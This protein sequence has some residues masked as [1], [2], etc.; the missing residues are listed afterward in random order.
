[1]LGWKVSNI[2]TPIH[3]IFLELIMGPT[4]SIFYEREPVES[5]IMKRPPRHVNQNMFSWNELWISMIQGMAIAF[6]ILSLYYT[7]MRSGYTPDYIR[8]IVFNTLIISN[9]FLTLVNR[10]FT[11]TID[12]TIRYKNA[13][14]KYV[15]LISLVFLC[16]LQFIKPV[17]ALFGLNA[18]Q[19]SHYML[20][21]GV[22]LI[23][24]GSF[25]LYK[26]AISQK[27]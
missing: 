22:S 8:S 24:T 23:V 17:Q 6:G 4:C 25:E 12:K 9:V 20:C 15:V 19:F 2:F 7:F 5:T 27:K 1:M 14:A 16:S 21:L 10:S 11:E 13:L 3:I 26:M 18:L